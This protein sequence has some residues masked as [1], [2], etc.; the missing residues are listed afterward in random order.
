MCIPINVNNIVYPCKSCHV[1]VNNK[2][3]AAQ[4]GIASLGFIR[5]VIN[6]TTLTTNISKA[7]MIPGIVFLVAVKFFV[8]EH[9]KIKSSSLPSRQQTLSLKVPIETTIKKVYFHQNLLLIWLS[10]IINSIT[11]L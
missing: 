8:L 9:K 6:L 7:Q 5:N 11:L 10:F 1:N 2:D 4:C 3:S